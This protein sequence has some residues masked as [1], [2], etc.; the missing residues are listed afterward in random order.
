M[1]IFHYVFNCGNFGNKWE[2]EEYRSKLITYSRTPKAAL[3]MFQD[4]GVKNWKAA[5]KYRILRPLAGLY[6]AGRFFVKGITQKGSVAALKSEFDEAGRRNRMFDALGIK[7]RSKGL[8]IY[9]NGKY[10]K[11]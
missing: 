3:K 11:E 6:Q 4:M 8:V 9:K 10:I 2:N 7:Q 5:Q 1:H